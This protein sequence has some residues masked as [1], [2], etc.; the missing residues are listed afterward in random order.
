M[1][2]DFDGT[3]RACCI[4][5]YRETN[6]GNVFKE[7]VSSVWKGKGISDLRNEHESN[8][9]SK[10]SFCKDCDQWAGFNIVNE[11]EEGEVL[12]RE[13][14]YSTYYNRIDRLDGW[15]KETRRMD[16]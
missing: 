3:A 1:T 9:Y 4:D 15:T 11:Y 12:I 6:L 10:N 2:I 8:K 13:T 5:A 7:G 14:R 16:E